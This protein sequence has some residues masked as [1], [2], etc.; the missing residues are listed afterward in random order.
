M[1]VQS[2]M[3]K[4]DEEYEDIQLNPKRDNLYGRTHETYEMGATFLADCAIVED[5]GCGAG[6]FMQYRAPLGGLTM[7]DGSKTP[8]ADKIVDLT[9]YTTETDGIF[10]RHVLEHNEDWTKIL[11]N[12][13]KSAKNKVCLILFTPMEKRTTIIAHEV[14]DGVDVPDISFAYSDIEGVVNKY[15]SFVY[16]GK[17]VTDTQYKEE[18]VFYISINR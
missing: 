15:G 11:T 17:L 8:F 12:A 16:S 10:I 7:V 5:W 9:K 1:K 4:W 18:H 13:L 2:K 14:I 3:G 6:T